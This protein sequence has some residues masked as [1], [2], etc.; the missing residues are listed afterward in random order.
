MI[1][2]NMISSRNEKKVQQPARKKSP[3]AYDELEAR[4]RSEQ[5]QQELQELP[6][7]QL[8]NLK[9]ACWLADLVAL[10][11]DKNIVD[12][13]VK[14]IDGGALPEK[15]QEFYRDFSKLLTSMDNQQLKEIHKL[16]NTL[17]TLQFIAK[18]AHY[19]INP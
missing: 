3:L 10:L 11:N 17:C 18:N 7:E 9:H 14:Y 4:L 8:L 16:L 19:D 1:E 15:S 12:G 13:C 2:V 5:Q 6:L